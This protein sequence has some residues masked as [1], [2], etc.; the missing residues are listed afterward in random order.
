MNSNFSPFQEQSKLDD[1]YFK[2]PRIWR[3]NTPDFYVFYYAIGAILAVLL[4]LLLLISLAGGQQNT[5]E[6]NLQEPPTLLNTDV[7]V[8]VTSPSSSSS[9][10]ATS[11]P[12]VIAATPSPS[13]VPITASSE[14]ISA[15]QQPSY[16]LRAEAYA[17]LKDDP[18]LSQ[19]DKSRAM[20]AQQKYE[21]LNLQAHKRLDGALN[22]LQKDH[23]TV[24]IRTLTRLIEQGEVLGDV[25]LQAKD[26]LPKAYIKKIEYFMLLGQISKASHALVEAKGAGIQSEE[27]NDYETKIKNLIKVSR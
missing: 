14:L 18:A 8:A 16:A 1:S 23:Y 15:E 12:N 24:S 21:A 17:K 2:T 25:Y 7:P 13:A 6:A 10:L 22:G 19:A 5:Q 20:T 26:E 11:E 9:A 4:I 3:F 27:L